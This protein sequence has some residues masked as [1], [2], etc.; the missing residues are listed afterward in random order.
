MR[1]AI[2]GSGHNALVAAFYLAKAGHTP[3]VIERRSVPGGC[4][5]TEEFAPGFRAPLVNS[6]GPLR[7]EVVRDMQL[8][9]RVEFLRPDPR[10]VAL[11]PDG[12]ALLMS[13]D[14]RRT[15]DAI[16]AFSAQD[17][18][19][20]GEFCDTLS[21]LG[22]F[23]AGM[24]EATPPS[25]SAPDAGELWDLLKSGRRFRALGKKDGFRLL[26]WAPMAAA[27]LVA[28]WFETDLLQA[29]VASRG[30]FG[31]SHGPWSAGTG[32]VLLLQA[33]VDPAPGGS[34]IAIKGGPGALAR[35][36]SEAAR[37]AG[38]EITTKASVARVSV[39]D[40]RASGV[41]LEDGTE[42]AADAVVSGADPRRT[43][44]RLVDPVELDP[45][46]LT[47]VR[48]FRARGTVAKLHLG[49]RDVP[50][51]TGTGSSADL[52]G[53]IHIAPGI[54]YLERAFDASKY[55]EASEEPWLDV[56]I[57]SLLDPSLAPDGRHVMSVHV[58]F[59]PYTLRSGPWDGAAR[60]RVTASIVRTL[61]RFA[62]GVGS[63][64]EHTQLLTPTDLEEQYG[65][66]GG[67][68]YH[69]ELALDQLFT[70]RPILGFAQ[71]RTPIERLYL[72]GAGTHP[73]V[74]ITGGSGQ[75][76]A[77]EIVEDLKR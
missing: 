76:A 12:Q 10:L 59:V 27:D 52:R 44:L 54:D 70:M 64:V 21:R 43:F 48:N 5:A 33:A 20:Y 53:R 61:E 74:G 22:E 11:A 26:R 77:R 4:V 45:G 24:L 35:A 56:T 41:V 55:G 7:A 3:I 47:K 46:F 13:S 16:H 31:T 1:I 9:R 34:T 72:C 50:R 73:G 39:R 14:R 51:F 2:I 68:I 49:L 62:P 69:G 23:I 6:I 40:G 28:E 42:I 18:A 67:H 32:A 30:V 57:P 17:A 8:E 71:Y 65:L 19:R 36:M 25:L 66:T 37:E 60:E 58:Q 38:A 15:A 63:L 29:V 75:N